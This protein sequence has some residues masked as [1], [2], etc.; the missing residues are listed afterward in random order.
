MQKGKSLSEAHRLAISQGRKRAYT[1]RKGK[2]S[3]E[4]K[5][6][7][8]DRNAL[9]LSGMNSANVSALTLTQR[10]DLIESQV[11]HIRTQLGGVKNGL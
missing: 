9:K 2:W 8:R 1:K 5:Q 10:L 4:A 11:K 6:R 3:A 7:L